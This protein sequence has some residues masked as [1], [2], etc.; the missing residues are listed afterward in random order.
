[1]TGVSPLSNYVQAN[2][3]NV[4][5]SACFPAALGQRS[6][7]SCYLEESALDQ[8]RMSSEDT[9]EQ[10]QSVPIVDS[11]MGDPQ[12]FSHGLAAYL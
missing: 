5:L 10:R 3:N 1:M 12:D 6:E 11:T 2:T 7:F 9:E 8:R 4:L